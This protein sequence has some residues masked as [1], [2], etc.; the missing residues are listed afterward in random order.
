[1]LRFDKKADRIADFLNLENKT[2]K[3]VN[4]VCITLSAANVLN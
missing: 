3:T 4:I 2:V 1:M